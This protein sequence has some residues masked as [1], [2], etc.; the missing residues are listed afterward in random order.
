MTKLLFVTQVLDMNDGVLG[1]YHEWVHELAQHFDRVEVICLA[2][3]EVA[4]PDNVRVH[5][6]GKERGAVPSVVY[7]TRFL[8]LAWRLRH[9]Y[10]VVCVHMNQEYIL[11]VGLLWQLLGKR[12]YMWRNH[13]AGS[14][15]TDVA[16]SFC[17]RIFCTS[18]HS[19]T[20]KYKKTVYMPVGVNV[21]RFSE[22]TPVARVPHSILF[23]ARIAPSKRPDLLLKALAVLHTKGEVFRASIYGSPTREDEVYYEGLKAQA[24]DLG[25]TDTVTFFPGVSNSQTPAV[26]Q[27]HEIVVNCSPSG[28]FDKTL[29]E[30]AASGCIVLSVS[31]DFARVTTPL[32]QFSSPEELATRIQFVW[33]M[34]PEN[35]K[36]TEQM[37]VRVASEHSLPHLISCLSEHM[38]PAPSF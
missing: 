8:R 18:K 19:Y 31:E 32:L 20:A 4:L 6:L 14:W 7:A 1:A 9:D 13:Y 21:V 23:L 28:M 2:Q 16:A 35:K 30:A 5:S 37:L 15:L 22:K 26:Y 12:I 33:E 10:D 3:G 25:L 29:F 36:E 27:A 11:I 24:Q 34:S 17:T 38:K